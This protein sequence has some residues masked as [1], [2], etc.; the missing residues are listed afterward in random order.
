MQVKTHLKV[1][2][3]LSHVI[4]GVQSAATIAGNVVG[5]LAQQA[6]TALQ[7]PNVSQTLNTLLWWPLTPPKQ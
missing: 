3:T 2:V 7:D 1:G 5:S 6:Q 4:Q